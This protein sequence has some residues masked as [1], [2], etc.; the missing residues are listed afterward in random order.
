[1]KASQTNW[2]PAVMI[3]LKKEHVHGDG[4]AAT[5]VLRTEIHQQLSG[6]KKML[7]LL[8]NCTHLTL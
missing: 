7:K 1:M 2:N 4:S 5:L 8:H 6:T 3:S